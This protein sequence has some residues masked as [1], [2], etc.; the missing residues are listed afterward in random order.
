MG[1]S[2][3]VTARKTGAIVLFDTDRTI[4]G[5]DGFA[6]S[7]AEEAGAT[8]TF[9]ADLASRIFASDAAVDHVFAASNQVVVRRSS[10][11][12]N[13]DIEA[14]SHVIRDFFLFYPDAVTG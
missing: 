5:Q 13:S 3:E 12:Q 9:P 1:Q 14:V 8:A 7:S 10:D 6:F 11:W 4:T 2:I